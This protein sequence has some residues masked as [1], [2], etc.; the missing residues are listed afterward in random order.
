LFWN[1]D[2]EPPRHRDPCTGQSE[3]VR[4]FKLTQLLHLDSL[5]LLL[6]PPPPPSSQQQQPLLLLTANVR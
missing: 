3:T 2:D 6:P 1:D 5:L 4:L